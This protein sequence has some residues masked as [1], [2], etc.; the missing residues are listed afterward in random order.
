MAGGRFFQKKPYEG[1]SYTVRGTR[2]VEWYKGSGWSKLD[3]QTLKVDGDQ[4]SIT[5]P[6]EI[7]HKL[8]EIIAVAKRTNKI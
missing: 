3:R 8:D 5:T 6:T 2:Y 1:K 7:F 4:C